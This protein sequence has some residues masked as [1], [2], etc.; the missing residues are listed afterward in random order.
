MND[1]LC[2]SPNS[3]F[4]VHRLTNMVFGES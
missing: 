1:E 2:K 4:I 3:S